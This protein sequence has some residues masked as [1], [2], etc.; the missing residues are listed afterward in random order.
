MLLVMKYDRL[1]RDVYLHEYIRREVVKKKGTIVAVDGGVDGDDPQAVLMRQV[2]LAFAQFERAMISRRTKLA[3]RYQQ[4]KGKRVSSN[5][6]FGYRVE[7]GKLAPREDEQVVVRRVRELHEEGL[8]TKDI[9]I[10][11]RDEG[12]KTRCGEP[13]RS[14]HI[15]RIVRNLE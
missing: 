5:P 14:R 7:G 2:L 11:I 4:R 15:E 8:S 9:R 6:P 12:H 1:A 10:K 3:M 13:W